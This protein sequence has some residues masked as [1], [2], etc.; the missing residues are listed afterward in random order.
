MLIER[1]TDPADPRIAIYRDLK[2]KDMRRD[3]AFIVEGKFILETLI[4]RSQFKLSSI[5]I[6]DDRILPLETLLARA[7]SEVPVYVT[8]PKIMAE[9]AGY[10]V[11]RGVL[12]AGVVGQTENNLPAH[13]SRFTRIAVLSNISNPDNIGAIF[14]NA[15]GLGIE[16]V[17]LDTQCCSPLYRKA[18]R[19]SMGATLVLPWVQHGS[20]EEIIGQLTTAG[21]TSHALSL[22]GA[23]KLED[24]LFEKRSAFVFGEEAYGLPQHVQALCLA[25]TIPMSAGTDSLNVAATSAIVF[26]TAR[27]QKL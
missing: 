22:Q 1:I 2:D 20:I 15:A 6:S 27:R 11:H 12:A 9:I 21:F 7:Q 8:T 23:T 17:I 16:A 18:I 25:L 26:D 14:R 5:F 19:V 13:L 24:I 4:T 10:N 3:G